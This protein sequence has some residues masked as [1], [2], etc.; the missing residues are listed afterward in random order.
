MNNNKYDFLFSA[1]YIVYDVS[2]AD[3][4]IRKAKAQIFNT[5][6]RASNYI[7]CKSDTIIRNLT[8]KKRIK[9]NIDGKLYA[10]RVLK[11][12]K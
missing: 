12:D 5:A 9:S 7:G 11:E 2:I 3:L 6:K 10:V 4:E 1:K 8:P